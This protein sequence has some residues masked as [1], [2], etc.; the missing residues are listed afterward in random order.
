MI[1][2][3]G[4][5]WKAKEEPSE[6]PLP[7]LPPARPA[8]APRPAQDA[9][10]APRRRGP[11]A[12]P[13]TPVAEVCRNTEAHHERR[14]LDW[15]ELAGE[16]R[17]VVGACPTCRRE[18]AVLDAA[19]RSLVETLPAL[20]PQMLPIDLERAGDRARMRCA[21]PRLPAGEGAM[22]SGGPL[23]GACWLGPVAY[24]CP[25]CLASLRTLLA[26]LPEES[27]R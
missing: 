21:G 8:S 14:G 3:R 11:A 25:S 10:P 13:W 17:L 5:V 2:R 27:V 20:G 19:L 22:F 26:A 16:R 9:Q 23:G 18:L 1:A 7:A 4:G 12:P 15:R 6:E 24:W